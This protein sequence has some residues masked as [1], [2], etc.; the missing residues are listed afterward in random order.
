MTSCAERDATAGGKTMV[1]FVPIRNAA[2]LEGLEESH[3]DQLTAIAGERKIHEGDRL[4]TRGEVADTFYIVE[5]G[6]I[7]LT[8]SLREFDE[9]GEFVVE[10]KG[11]LDALGWSSL[12]EPKT[13]I[14]S[15]YCTS[16]GVVVTLPGEDLQR[17]FEADHH[18]GERISSNLNALIGERVRKLQDLW[19]HELE[20][21]HG[22]VAYW[23]HT[24]MSDRL[25]SV[26]QKNS[27]AN[28]VA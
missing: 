15:A 27:D 4:F 8:L 22:R 24:K 21:S 19:I 12:V 26:L 7:A 5:S 13:S 28:A 10:E 14:Y 3:L 6:G 1:N 9:Y 18:L 11:A 25:R 23:S 17:L 16:D 2:I 20:N